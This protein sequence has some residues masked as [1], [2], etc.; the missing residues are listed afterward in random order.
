[1]SA[2][3]ESAAELRDRMVSENHALRQFNAELRAALQDLYEL[4]EA[5][6]TFENRDIEPYKYDAIVDDVKG[7]AARVLGRKVP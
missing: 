2:I 1:M 5:D 4:V 3:T 6:A 7:R